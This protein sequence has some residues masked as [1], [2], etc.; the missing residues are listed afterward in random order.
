MGGRAE[1]RGQAREQGRGRLGVHVLPKQ[2]LCRGERKTRRPIAIEGQGGLGTTAR[3]AWQA[4][5]RDA[6]PAPPPK[7]GANKP[8]LLAGGQ[9]VAAKTAGH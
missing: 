2:V 9:K 6:L 7:P 1:R 3:H 5:A 4:H 8:G